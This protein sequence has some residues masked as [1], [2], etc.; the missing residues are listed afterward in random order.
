MMMAIASAS[1]PWPWQELVISSVRQQQQS[2]I[3]QF[4]ITT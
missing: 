1:G 2:L 3:E 4:R